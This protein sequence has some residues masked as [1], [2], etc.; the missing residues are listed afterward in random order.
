MEGVD[1]KR[2]VNSI[3]KSSGLNVNDIEEKVEAKQR[4]ISGLISKEGAAQ[5]VA[6]F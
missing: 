2:I 3:V 6:A 5:I 4:K 1:Y